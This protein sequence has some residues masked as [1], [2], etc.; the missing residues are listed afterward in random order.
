MCNLCKCYIEKDVRERYV[1]LSDVFIVDLMLGFPEDFVVSCS[2]Y[3]K[4]YVTPCVT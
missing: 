2:A 1:C 4:Q 3:I